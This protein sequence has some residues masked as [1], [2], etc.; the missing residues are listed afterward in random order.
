MDIASARYY[1]DM[2]LVIAVKHPSAFKHSGDICANAKP[3]TLAYTGIQ[4]DSYRCKVCTE[5]KEDLAVIHV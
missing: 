5:S 1:K 3:L 2:Y 4:E